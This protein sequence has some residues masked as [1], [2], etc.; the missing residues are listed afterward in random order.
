MTIYRY[1][2]VPCFALAATACAASDEDPTL[3]HY[4]SE[5]TESVEVLAEELSAHYEQILAETDLGRIQRMEATHMEDMDMDMGR[6]RDARDSMAACNEHMSN[7]GNMSQDHARQALH[8]A[9]GA[10]GE[11]M[12][13]V[14]GEMERHMNVM[15]AASTIDSALAEEHQHETAM[16]GI[17][18]RMRMHDDELGVAMQAMEDEGMSMMCSM[19]SHM[20]RQH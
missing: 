10:M 16:D 9:Q 13:E 2:F 18:G 15:D 17:V 14:T 8:D 12:S 11:V 4:G 7:M 5:M 1:V 6:M 3:N 20:H 19:T